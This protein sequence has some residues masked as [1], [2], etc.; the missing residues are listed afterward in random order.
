MTDLSP[1]NEVLNDV[2]QRTT[3]NLGQYEQ[4][5]AVSGA[6]R[7]IVFVHGFGGHYQKTWGNL[8]DYI[9][10]D[11][12]FATTDIYLFGF[13]TGVFRYFAA[14]LDALG[15]RLRTVLLVE[16]GGQYGSVTVIAHSMGGLV[17]KEA[18]AS[19]LLSGDAHRLRPLKHVVFCST[20]HL[21]E[22]KAT[23]LALLGTHLGQL[24]AL[25]SELID[26]HRVWQS[27]VN[28]IART[29]DDIV[30]ERYTAQIRITNVWGLSDSVVSRANA[31][32]LTS[33][34]D[35]VTV[36]G[37]HKS[38]T[39]PIGANDHVYRTVSQLLQAGEGYPDRA[40]PS[41]RMIATS[42]TLEDPAL[43]IADTPS[44]PEKYESLCRK[45]V[46]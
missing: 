43:H 24:R 35:V 37:S 42:L 22:V 10:A 12:R 3:T 44:I 34:R 13:R 9:G 15:Q 8:P 39:K 19:A 2:P 30:H 46:L 32:A 38:M 7:L 6:E 14:P 28:Y 27:R 16:R 4:L 5:R 41:E 23:A 11:P 17:L 20:P 33:D 31:S 25:R 29:D 36:A 40:L 1:T 21:G 26:T 18:V 45:L